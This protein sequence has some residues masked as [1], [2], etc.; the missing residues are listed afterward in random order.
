MPKT[1]VTVNLLDEDGN[2]MAIVGRVS[3]ALK[4]AGH[5]DLATRYI[6]EALSG[7]YYHLLLVTMGYV[8][9]T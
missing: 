9:V 4:R 3:K 8:E 2:A 6:E 5:R 7:D 1:D